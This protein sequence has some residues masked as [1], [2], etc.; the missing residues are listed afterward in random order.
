MTLPEL[1]AELDAKGVRTAVIDGK[2]RVDAPKNALSAP[3]RAALV[4]HKA[5]LLAHMI[6]ADAGA[7]APAPAP[8]DAPIAPAPLRV[9]ITRIPLDDLVVG[10][11]LAR[12][13]LRIVDGAAFPDGRNFRPTIYLVNDG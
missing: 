4:A 3:L 2:L 8:A 5:A 7:D 10:D 1:L 11:Y 13:K 6:G 12:H 9:P